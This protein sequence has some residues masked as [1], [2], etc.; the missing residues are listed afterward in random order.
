[1]FPAKATMRFGLIIYPSDPKA[2][3]AAIARA[4]RIGERMMADP[5][6]RARILEI[7]QD[8]WP[9]FIEAE[10]ADEDGMDTFDHADIREIGNTYRKALAEAHDHWERQ[11]AAWQAQ[12]DDILDATPKG[13]PDG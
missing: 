9:R 12:R 13:D 11:R 2:P 5:I 4:S 1:V 10:N 6:F 8:D 7:V 3:A